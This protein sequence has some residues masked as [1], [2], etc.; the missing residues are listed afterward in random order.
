MDAYV[1]VI[2]PKVG[3]QKIG[4]TY[5]LAKRLAAIQAGSPVLYVVA[6]FQQMPR[7]EAAAVEELA[8][9]IL[10]PRHIRSEWFDVT[11]AEAE[12]AVLQAM[13][14]YQAGARPRMPGD[15]PPSRQ[16]KRIFT[17]WVPEEDRTL[18]KEVEAEQGWSTQVMLEHALAGLFKKYGKACPPG[19]PSNGQQH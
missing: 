5:D 8:H 1:Y 13:E 2:G 4:I 14:A 7:P 6:S 18:L 12:A 17:I 19:F 16:G 10:K 15:R 9:R 11:S 3:P